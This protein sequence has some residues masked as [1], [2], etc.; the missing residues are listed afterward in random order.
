MN[1]TILGAGLIAT[2]IVATAG[3]VKEAN[4]Y[5][6]PNYY[7]TLRGVAVTYHP[8]VHSEPYFNID[9]W[10]LVDVK[11]ITKSGKYA[12]V[13]YP[14]NGAT[15]W[16]QTKYIKTYEDDL[17]PD[18]H[19]TANVLN[20]RNKPTTKGSYVVSQLKRGTGVVILK[21]SN[22]WYYVKPLDGVGTRG[23]VSA[24]YIK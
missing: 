22:G 20:V 10:Q 12:K 4:A 2:G 23:W 15:G 11:S 16:I 3:V 19:V 24:R 1:K 14:E 8:S 5:E 6:L 17:T 21:S 7:V 9:K 18:K 13:Y